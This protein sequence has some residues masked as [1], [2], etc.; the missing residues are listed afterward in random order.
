MILGDALPGEDSI[1]SSIDSAKD[2]SLFDAQETGRLVLL[3][4]WT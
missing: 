3:S 1:S 4:R 2:S